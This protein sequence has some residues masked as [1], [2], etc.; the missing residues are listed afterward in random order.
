MDDTLFRFADRADL[1]LWAPVNDTV[2]GGQSFSR[3]LP[4]EDGDAC[5][6]GVVSFENGGGFAS[7][8]SQPRDLGRP[9]ALAYVLDVR[10]DGKRYKLNVRM[11][12][13]LDGLTYQAIFQPPAD[14]WI[15]I[16]LPLV[17]FAATQR[18][19]TIAAAP[20]LDPAR[21]RQLGLLIADRQE[22]PFRLD[23]RRIVA[24]RLPRFDG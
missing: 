10:G 22:G 21:V 4:V 1:A 3:L 11:D 2:M 20:A 24:R 7:I 23:V 5:F 8:R 13:R 6:E 18:G 17:S 9:G 16:E 19:R 14:L 12:D 15:E